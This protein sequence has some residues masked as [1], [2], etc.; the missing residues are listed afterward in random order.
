MVS[1]TGSDVIVVSETGSDVIVVS[2]TGSDAIVVSDTGSDAIVVSDTGSDV[3]VVSD[4]GSDVTV[5]SETG[6]PVER[7]NSADEV[8]TNTG[9]ELGER[10][11]CEL[12]AERGSKG[13]ELDTEGIGRSCEANA[14]GIRRSCE[15]DAEGIRRSCEVATEEGLTPVDSEGMLTAVVAIES[16][17]LVMGAGDVADGEGRILPPMVESGAAMTVDDTP[18]NMEVNGCRGAEVGSPVA[19]DGRM[20]VGVASVALLT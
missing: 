2:D 8:V 14:E 17:P 16:V 12:D 1:D 6:S 18:P 5:V 4:T 3:T 13:C 11:S 7:S 10:S 20:K 9:T 19:S 15:A